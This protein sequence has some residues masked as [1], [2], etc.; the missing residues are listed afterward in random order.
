MLTSSWQ[1][2]FQQDHWCATFRVGSDNKGA[3]QKYLAK[4]GDNDLTQRLRN[5]DAAG[6]DALQLIR[7]FRNQR[8]FVQEAGGVSSYSEARGANADQS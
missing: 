4:L 8:T 2:R 7:I 5:R 6:I 3:H 1:R